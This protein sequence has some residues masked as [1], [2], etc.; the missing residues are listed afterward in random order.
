MTTT[1]K[2]NG[3]N[4]SLIELT[5]FVEKDKWLLPQMLLALSTNSTL[6]R[7]VCCPTF[8]AKVFTRDLQDMLQLFHKT[9]PNPFEISSTLSFLFEHATELKYRKNH[10]QYFTPQKVA[11][12]TIN[13]LALKNGQNILEPGTG[14][15]IFPT[16]ILK[17]YPEIADSMHYI[18]VENDPLLALSAA[19]SLDWVKAPCSWKIFYSNFLELSRTDFEQLCISKFDVIISNPPFVRFHRLGKRNR[20]SK[21]LGLTNLAG[22]HSYFLA[23]S[24]TFIDKGKMAFILPS[25]MRRTGYGSKLF[26]SLERRFSIDEMGIYNDRNDYFIGPLSRRDFSQSLAV[27]SAASVIFF[28]SV[29][30]KAETKLPEEVAT[31]KR[32]AITLKDLASV[33]RGISTG[34]NAF[35]ILTEDSVSSLAIPQK[36]LRKIMPTKVSIDFIDAILTN[37]RMD[38]FSKQKKQCYLLT[39]DSKI[40]FDDLHGTLKQYI[41]DGEALG[42]HT[43]ATSKARDPWYSVKTPK[44]A[45]DLLFTYMFRGIPK[46]VVNEARVHI[47][48]NL[49]GVYL[50][51]PEKYSVKDLVELTKVL[52]FSVADWVQK[53]SG[54]RLYA[55]GLMKFEPHDLEKMPIHGKIFE[56]IMIK[57]SCVKTI[58]RFL[59]F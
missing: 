7:I 59:D 52:N 1:F 14:T 56:T 23:R 20:T 55:G 50:N 58:G 57:K 21:L 13:R 31:K 51:F 43:L 17:S 33:H 48:T 35:F 39:I 19:L 11:I 26:S 10:G 22:L 9:T 36:W 38:N 40:K 41:R 32:N 47:L 16:M 28:E 45:P 2:N 25:E 29:E 8:P 4:R 5:G 27:N 30:E 12:E 46:F 54:Y 24:A 3:A 34:A 49:L 18:G 53:E 6:N 37:D 42:L 15:G 44:R